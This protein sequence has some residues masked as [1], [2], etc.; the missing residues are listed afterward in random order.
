[1]PSDR[2]NTEAT[3]GK[4]IDLTVLHDRLMINECEQKVS[5]TVLMPSSVF[6]ALRLAAVCEERSVVG[7]ARRFIRE[8]LSRLASERSSMWHA[9]RVE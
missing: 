2:N 5:L 9:D 6:D 3:A 8:G 1:M 4:A 7:M